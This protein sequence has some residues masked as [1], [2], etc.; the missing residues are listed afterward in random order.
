MQDIALICKNQRQ[1]ERRQHSNSSLRERL[2]TY[3]AHIRP[4]HNKTSASCKMLYLSVK[5]RRKEETQ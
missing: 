4:F 5:N 3:K 2:R 1:K